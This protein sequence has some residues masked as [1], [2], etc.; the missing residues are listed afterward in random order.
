MSNATEKDI[1]D[2]VL[3]TGNFTIQAE[4]PNGKTITMSGYIYSHN[5][6]EDISKQIDVYHDVVDRQ[7]LKAEIP[8]LEAKLEQK[9]T[10]LHD[11]TDALTKLRD[12]RNSGQKTSAAEVK[13][14]Q[15]LSSNLTMCERDVEKG[16]EALKEARDNA[17]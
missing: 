13:M 16:R 6:K 10:H 8:V 2:G 17:K 14:I 1:Q 7:R 4:M 3:T 12:K 9:I 15:E 11:I 5:T